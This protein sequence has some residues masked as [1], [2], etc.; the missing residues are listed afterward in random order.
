[1]SAIR[2]WMDGWHVGGWKRWVLIEPVSEAATWGTVGLIAMLAL[3]LPAF[4]DTTDEDWL[5][6][7]ELAVHVPRPLRQRSRRARHQA[8]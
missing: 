5:K 1:M 2:A 7:S 3:A 8:Q 4:R 6:K